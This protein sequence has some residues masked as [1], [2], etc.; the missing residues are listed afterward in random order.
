MHKISPLQRPFPLMPS[1]EG[2]EFSV[3][4]SGTRYKRNDLLMLRF[5]PE[6]VAAGVFTKSLTCSA[7]VIWCKNQLRWQRRNNKNVAALIVNAGNANAFT[8]EAGEAAVLKQSGSLA[9]LLECQKEQIFIA[10]TGVIGEPLPVDAII[11]HYPPMLRN[12]KNDNAWQEAVLATQ[13][14]DTFSKAACRII[15]IEGQTV[16]INAIAKGSGMIEPNMATMLAWLFTD[17]CISQKMLQQIL[18]QACH[19]S[20]NAITVDSDTST[21][22]TLMAFATQKAG[23]SPIEDESHRAYKIF[24]QAVEEVLVE[25]A[26]LVVRDGEGASKFIEINV[27]GAVSERSAKV[28]AKSIAN[29]PLVKTAIAGEDANWGRIMA[30]AGKALEPLDA[31]LVSLYFGDVLIVEKGLLAPDYRE[32]NVAEHLKGQDISI[33]LD[34]HLGE[35]QATVWTCDLTHDYIDINADYRS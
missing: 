5:A 7:P 17:A 3:A 12:L 29:S 16:K 22:D 18:E 11:A 23:H 34:L 35:G 27:K 25:L 8:G 13:T 10:S 6:T 24:S 19:K 9:A 30:A 21:S 32:E 2:V 31:S 33:A 26:Q 1:I 20:F 14:T 28:I 15:E 4:H